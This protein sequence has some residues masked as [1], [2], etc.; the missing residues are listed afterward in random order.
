ML[1]LISNFCLKYLFWIFIVYLDKYVNFEGKCIY[2][3]YNVL[4][5]LVVML[6]YFCIFHFYGH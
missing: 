5:Q 4:Q 3:E 2:E 6:S 1:F